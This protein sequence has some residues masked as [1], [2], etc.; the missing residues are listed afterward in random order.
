MFCMLNNKKTEMLLINMKTNKM[1]QKKRNRKTELFLTAQIKT[2]P[3]GNSFG[4]TTF[5]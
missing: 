1:K 3:R 5:W 2:G 4:G